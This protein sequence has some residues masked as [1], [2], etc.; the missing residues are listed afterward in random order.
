MPNAIILEHLIRSKFYTSMRI[1]FS[2]FRDV[3][4]T[5]I[6]NNGVV[7]SLSARF[8][9]KRTG[10][11]RLHFDVIVC[12]CSILIFRYMHYNRAAMAG[13]IHN[14]LSGI[15]WYTPHRINVGYLVSVRTEQH[16]P[17]FGFDFVKNPF[18]PNDAV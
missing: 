3:L 4:I 12:L 16:I 11:N 13:T 14:V 1:R 6:Y 8:I 7:M 18:K 9:E 10:R 5:L 15:G 2:L 17:R